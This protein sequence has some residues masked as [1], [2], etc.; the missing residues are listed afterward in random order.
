VDD[1][2]D[3]TIVVIDQVE[4]LQTILDTKATITQLN[5]KQDTLSIA[6]VAI[7]KING[8]Q[9]SLDSKYSKTHINTLLD[10]KQENQW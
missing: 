3:N 10:G 5:Q 6:S 9:T 2:I 4:W 8:L 7:D 1:L